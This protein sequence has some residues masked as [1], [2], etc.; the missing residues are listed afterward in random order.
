MISPLNRLISHPLGGDRG[1]ISAP[2]RFFC[3]TPTI[4]LQKFH[5]WWRRIVEMKRSLIYALVFALT[6]TRL[7]ATP[8]PDQQHRDQQHLEAVRKKVARCVDRHRTVAVETF[9]GRRLQGRVSEAGTDDFVLVY[10]ARATTLSYGE[11][12]KI[13]WP[14]PVWRQAQAVAIAAGVTAAI[15]GLVVL[16]GGLKG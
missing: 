10:G 16:L 11:V 12:K 1:L 14:S 7:S 2:L 5:A 4:P 9:D 13:K 8:A 15:F 3:R 6:V